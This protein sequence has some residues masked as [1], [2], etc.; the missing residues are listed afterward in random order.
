MALLIKNAHVYTPAD[1]GIKDVLIVNDRVAAVEDNLTV[2]MP[3]LATLDAKGLILT[4]GFID[5]HIHVTGGGG[6]G[7]PRTRTPELVLSELIACGTTSVVGVSGTDGTSRSIPNLLAKIR[8]LKAEGVSAWMYT[9]NYA[10]PPTTL[11]TCVRDD[12]FFVPEVVGVKIAM[13]DHRS[14]F[15]SEDEVLRLLTQIR[16]GA[17]VAGKLGV[18]HIHLGNIPGPFEIFGDIVKR[19]FPIR[20]IRPTH[21]ARDKA[22]FEGAVK[23]AVAGG[24]T[25]VT[26]GGSCAFATPAHAAFEAL[27]AGVPADHLTMS[28]DGHGSVPRFNE[29]GEMVGLGVGGVA[30]NLRD[31]KRLIGELNVPM[32]TA[33]ALLTRNV[34]KALELKGKGEVAAGSSADLCLFDENMNLR[35][36]FALGQQMMRDGEIVVKGTFEE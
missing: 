13:G 19:G 33:L 35:H 26:T 20:H 28:S 5:Q 3:D 30:S 27:K 18:L 31:F 23:F 9:S 15:P 6:E 22:V 14:S 11:T 16:V 24:Y 12:L 10:Y 8:A 32:E 34:A 7:G 1:A 29:K 25:D 21:C 2:T 17:M 4:P 36:V